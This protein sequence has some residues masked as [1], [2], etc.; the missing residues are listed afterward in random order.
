M[1]KIQVLLLG[2]V[3]IGGILAV[4]G[5]AIYALWWLTLLAIRRVPMIGKRHRHPDW[6]R[7]NGPG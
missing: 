6:D 7:L 1:E 3:W 5:M 4:V 2:I